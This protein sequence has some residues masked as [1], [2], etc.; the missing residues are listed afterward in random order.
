MP[1]PT[2]AAELQPSRSLTPLPLPAAVY[3]LMQ[4]VV[5]ALLIG[6]LLACIAFQSR[7]G[8]LPLTLV[9]SAESVCMVREG[10][11]TFEPVHG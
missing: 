5:V 4:A 9:K 8:I 2:S 3:T 6:R 11:T 10:V 7:V 1:S